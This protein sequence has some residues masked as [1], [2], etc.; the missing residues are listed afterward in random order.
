MKPKMIAALLGCIL[1]LS[2]NMAAAGVP[3]S[4]QIDTGLRIVEK[5][6]QNDWRG[7]EA[8]VV[9][10]IRGS[11]ERVSIDGKA[12]DIVLGS[13]IQPGDTITTGS[14]GHVQWMTPD[15]AAFTLLPDAVGIIRAYAYDEA[16]KGGDTCVIDVHKGGFQYVTGRMNER[17]PGKTVFRTQ[18][19]EKVIPVGS[20]GYIKIE[21]NG[22][23]AYFVTEGSLNVGG[24]RYPQGS[25]V[26]MD[27]ATGQAQVFSSAVDANG[28]VTDDAA[29]AAL[30][31]MGIGENALAVLQTAYAAA[32]ASGQAVSEQVGLAPESEQSPPA[33]IAEV[34]YSPVDDEI[35]DTQPAS[36]R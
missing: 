2:G 1:L 31:D 21:Q 3:G 6:R 15:R 4:P 13:G 9:I 29:K 14:D 23:I 8:G 25:V 17:S 28:T 36:V 24:Q 27:V 20:A 7:A 34:N 26:V 19:T 5:A 32:A 12:R 18:G 35:G 10:G 11:V 30:A 33:P 22:R 16:D